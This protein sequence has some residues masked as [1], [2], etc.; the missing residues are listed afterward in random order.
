[1][2]QNSSHGTRVS[3]TAK[4]GTEFLKTVLRSLSFGTGNRYLRQ[5]YFNK[6]QFK[7]NQH[8]T[9]FFKISQFY[10]K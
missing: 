2:N 1:M 7:T 8:K 9:K 5:L 4:I 6:E 10:P 3:E